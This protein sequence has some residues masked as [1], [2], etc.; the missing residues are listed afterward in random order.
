[1]KG[2][3]APPIGPHQQWTCANGCGQCGVR[4]I[5]FAWRTV[6][7]LSTGQVVERDTVK[8]D[9]SSCCGAELLLWDDDL[10]D[11]VEFKMLE[12]EEVPC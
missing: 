12:L 3:Q 8:A 9:V 4:T 1:M 6:T 2:Q 7:D 5:D 10:Q 11:C